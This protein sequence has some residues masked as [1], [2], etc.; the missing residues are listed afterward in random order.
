MNFYPSQQTHRI[1]KSMVVDAIANYVMQTTNV[2]VTSVVKLDEI[3]Q[4]FRHACGVA[5]DVM[6]LPINY[7]AVPELNTNVAYY[8]CTYCGT[9]YVQK[10]FM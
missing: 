7:F 10:D 1:N 9:L 3:T 2:G 5:G 8:F 4:N 6:F